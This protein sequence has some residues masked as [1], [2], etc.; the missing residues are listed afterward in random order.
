MF[1]GLLHQ[2]DICVSVYE[3]GKVWGHTLE[4]SQLCRGHHFCVNY[5][6]DNKC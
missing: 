5:V 4:K 1:T 3:I 6:K 2:N